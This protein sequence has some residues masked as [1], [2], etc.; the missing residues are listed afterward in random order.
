MTERIY[1]SVFDILTINNYIMSSRFRDEGV[2]RI[3]YHRIEIQSEQSNCFSRIRG[4]TWN[5]PQKI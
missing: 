4:Q 5:I 3:N 2:A 1:V